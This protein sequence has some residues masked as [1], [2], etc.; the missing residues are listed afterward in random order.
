MPVTFWD[1][2]GLR[3]HVF[4]AAL[5]DRYLSFLSAALGCRSRICSLPSSEISK[6]LS[7]TPSDH[8]AG[9][10]TPHAESDSGR[11][12]PCIVRLCGRNRKNRRTFSCFFKKDRHFCHTSKNT[13]LLYSSPE[14]PLA[15]RESLSFHDLKELSILACEPRHTPAVI[16][17]AIAPLIGQRSLENIYFCDNLSSIFILAKAG[18][19]FSLVPDIPGQRDPGLSY[20]PMENIPPLQFGLYYKNLSTHPA[21]KRF[22]ELMQEEF[23]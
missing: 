7:P 20:I 23:K 4:P 21:L 16:S 6:R 15:S 10:F 9:S 1:V 17:S 22:I 18:L 13:C 5:P 14:H 2:P 3:R 19:G 11:N 12:Y 8:Q